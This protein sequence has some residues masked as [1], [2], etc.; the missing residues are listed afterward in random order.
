MLP[1][2]PAATTV[3]A[4]AARRRRTP[5]P[6]TAADADADADDDDNGETMIA[7]L[8]VNESYCFII[9]HTCRKYYYVAV[10]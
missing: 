1:H 6:A 3:H 9:L 4:T 10:F 2:P 5:Y 7:T 8:K